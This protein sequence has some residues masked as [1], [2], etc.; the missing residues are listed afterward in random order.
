MN[1][2]SPSSM[3]DMRSQKS[4]KGMEKETEN[5]NVRNHDDERALPRLSDKPA[6]SKT[7]RSPY[8]FW[9]FS[10]PFIDEP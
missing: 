9:R 8:L 1:Q 2:I 6:S 5:A 3:H 10:F 4:S 7:L